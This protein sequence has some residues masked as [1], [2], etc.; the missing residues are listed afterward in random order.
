MASSTA[1]ATAS[2]NSVGGA[3]APVVVVQ[4]RVY[5]VHCYNWDITERNG[6]YLLQKVGRRG[7]EMGR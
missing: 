7:I 3:E 5:Y 6:N 2:N 4:I 1:E